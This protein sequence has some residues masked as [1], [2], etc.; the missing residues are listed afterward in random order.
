MLE[1]NFRLRNS[2]SARTN[3][4]A[5][6]RLAAEHLIACG[7]RNIAF[8]TSPLTK[9]YRRTILTGVREALREAGLRMSDSCIYE[10]KAERELDNGHYEFEMGKQLIREFLQN[11]A[12]FTAIIAINDLTAL[13][14]IQALAQNNIS[15]PHDISVISFDNIPYSNMISPPLTT[16]DLPSVTLGASSCNMLIESLTSSRDG[17]NGIILEFEGKLIERSSV[18]HIHS[19]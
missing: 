7:H 6:G 16:V 2:L 4:I 12:S 19:R 17:P 13:G 14:I 3:Y 1:S 11:K 9:S 5:A 8:L 18:R 15:V 10:A